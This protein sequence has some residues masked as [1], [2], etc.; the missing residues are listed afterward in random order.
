MCNWFKSLFGKKC[1][2]E[3]GCCEEKKST[4]EVPVVDQTEKVISENTTPVQ[5]TKA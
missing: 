3:H 2:C 1:K 4:T 5:D